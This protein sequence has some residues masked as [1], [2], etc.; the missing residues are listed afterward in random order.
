MKQIISVFVALIATSF[1]YSQNADNQQKIK[2]NLEDY[3][4]FEREN[5]HVQFNKTIYI[6][7]EN[8]AFKGYVFNKQSSFPNMNTTNV[9]LV[10]YDAQGQ[11]IQKQLLHTSLGTFDGIVTL[12]EKIA[13]GK[14]RF[15]FYT[16]WMNNFMEDESFAQNIEIINLKESYNLKTNQPNY[17]A[18]SIFFNPE[19]GSFIKGIS[20]TMG[21]QIKDCNDLGI[22]IIEGLVVDSKGKTITTFFTNKMGYGKFELTPDS[23]ETYSV[24]I[25]TDKLKMEKQ[26][27]KATNSGL[28]ITY[29]NNL[30]NNMLE[31]SVKTNSDGV[32][33]YQNKNYTLLIHQNGKYIQK[34]FNFNDKNLIQILIFDK[35]ELSNGVNSIR[36]IDENLNEI[37]ERLLYL[38]KQPKEIPA[39]ETQ[40]TAN[41]SIHLFGKINS[42]VANL[43]ISILP[44]ETACLDQKNSILGTLNLNAYL[45]KPVL[46]NYIYFDRQNVTRAFD[47][48][49]LMLNQT[50]SKYFWNNIMSHKP[51]ESYTFTKGITI[52]GTIVKPL[53]PKT[54]YKVA[55]ISLKNKIFE[56]AILDKN[57]KFSFDNFFA[58]DSTAYQLELMDEKN[59]AIETKMIVNILNNDQPFLKKNFFDGANCQPIKDLNRTFAFSNADL[60]KKRIA[61]N[62]IVVQNNYKKPIYIHQTEMNNQAA[63]AYK[64]GET[65]FGSVLDFIG[66][67]GYVTG[68]D[69]ENSAYVRSSRHEYSGNE[70]VATPAIFVDNFQILDLNVLYD[71]DLMNVDEIYIDKIGTSTTATGGYGTIR[72]YLKKGV[73]NSYLKKKHTTLIVKSGFAKSKTFKNIEF[74]FSREFY[75]F[76][77]LQWSPS[78]FL[79]A[80][81]FFEV[82]FP[83]INQ[84][85]VLVVIEGFTIEGQLISEIKKLSTI[86]K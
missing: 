72:I 41:D 40:F 65:D 69:Q 2:T 11:V 9:Q 67:N 64:M 54:K 85:E 59:L 81:Q 42:K 46:N 62:E 25:A 77:T 35:N 36:I 51:M 37:A 6:S 7:N 21:I 84:K 66:R 33:L 16:N 43:S 17:N 48:E 30:P 28:A 5:I 74:P 75:L 63:K 34:E 56:E 78:V 31:V 44:T 71:L 60:E 45:E 61:L 26:L 39:L 68:V 12:D 15:H 80:N 4:H 19:S 70:S 18:V 86:A 58:R 76:G 3:F 27:P 29:N 38:N 52:N 8:I 57:N 22:Q 73:N 24:K 10:I 47:M 82:S 53:N 50:K 20:N 79:D 1:G 14:Y 83:K 49:L 55:L 23:N 13:S 32:N